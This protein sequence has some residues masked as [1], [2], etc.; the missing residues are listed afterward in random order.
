MDMYPDGPDLVVFA[1]D[2]PED[3]KNWP[4]WKKRIVVLQ[5]CFLSF[6]A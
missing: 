5:V 6:V 2:D 3:S 4:D 1:R